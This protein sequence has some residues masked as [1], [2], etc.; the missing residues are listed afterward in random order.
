M[1]RFFIQIYAQKSVKQIWS[2]SFDNEMSFFWPS[3]HSLR[4]FFDGVTENNND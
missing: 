2:F 3:C 4:F 1:K